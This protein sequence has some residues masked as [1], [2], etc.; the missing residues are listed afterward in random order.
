M[1]ITFLCFLFAV[2]STHVVIR[3]FDP[4]DF[5]DGYIQL[6]FG[7]FIIVEEKPEDEGQGWA[8]GMNIRNLCETGTTFQEYEQGWFPPLFVL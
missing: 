3:R 5:G 8:F 4:K 1:P 6:R 7:D 2:N